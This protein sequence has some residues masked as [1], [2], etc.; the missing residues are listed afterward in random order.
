MEN[1][2]HRFGKALIVLSILGMLATSYLIVQHYK[3]SGG[4]FCNVSDYVSCD[5]VNKS[6]YAVIFNVPVSILGLGTYALFL[7]ISIALFRNW[8][9]K[10][11]IPAGTI[12]AAF[13]LIFSLRL[14]L[15]EFFYLRAVCLFCVAQQIII[16]FIFIIFFMLWR[17][18]R[19]S[20]HF[21]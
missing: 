17:R 8:N 1:S 16:I 15:I 7:A 20:S 9:A 21:L 12:L 18:Q 10:K 6:R 13:G 19:K 4:S 2:L 5:I 11:L 3:D 14:T